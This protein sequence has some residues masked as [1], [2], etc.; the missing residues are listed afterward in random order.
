VRAFPADIPLEMQITCIHKTPRNDPY[1]IRQ[2]GGINRTQNSLPISQADCIRR[3]IAAHFFVI[4]PDG[5][6]A[7]VHVHYP[8]LTLELQ[9]RAISP[10]TPTNYAGH[11]SLRV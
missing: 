7:D 10:L 2:V 4:A 1:T 8:L 11:F 3:S 6:R 5:T 9:E